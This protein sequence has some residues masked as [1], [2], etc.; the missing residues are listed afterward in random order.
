[1]CAGRVC[2]FV[3]L[4]VGDYY[5]TVCLLPVLTMHQSH[6]RRDKVMAHHQWMI[7]SPTVPP[8]HGK[9]IVKML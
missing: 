1:M 7:H 6:M 9:E 3:K 2:V 5:I 8:R 4:R